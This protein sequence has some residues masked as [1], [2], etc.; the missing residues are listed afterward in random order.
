MSS[1]IFSWTCFT[2]LHMY[3]FLSWN[4]SLKRSQEAIYWRCN[5]IC[6]RRHY[7]A[8]KMESSDLL[9]NRTSHSATFS[10][11]TYLRLLYVYLWWR[12]HNAP[13]LFIQMKFLVVIVLI[14]AHL[15]GWSKP[16]A[17]S[18][19]SDSRPSRSS[20]VCGT[21]WWSLSV[22]S[23]LLS[24]WETDITLPRRGICYLYFPA[25]K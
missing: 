8:Q 18:Y 3:I 21:P 12:V 13:H 25:L 2:N 9:S 24:W 20:Y 19:K 7:Y 10:S 23:V 5:S 4:K 6:T 11:Y 1:G 16:M 22:G 17:G 14:R 15:S